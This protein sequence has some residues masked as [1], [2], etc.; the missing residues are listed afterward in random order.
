M[1]VPAA[2][3]LLDVWERGASE[4]PVSRA[5]LLLSVALPATS[6][7][8]LTEM[9]LEERDTWLLSL[10][11]TLF[12]P[13]LAIRTACRHCGESLEAALSV[14]DVRL[15]AGAPAPLGRHEIDGY[16]LSLRAAS[17][18][19]LIAAAR[20]G[21]ASRTR[22]ALFE[23]CV[24][25]ARCSAAGPVSVRALPAHVANAISERLAAAHP[26]ADFR[27]DFTCPACDRAWSADFDVGSFLWQELSAWVQR[28]LRDVA[29]LA[30]AYGWTERESLA[31]SPTRRHLYLELSRA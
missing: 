19:D 5:L 25:E 12:G 9:S 8:E 31:L 20:L 21:D 13:Q 14:D 18:A 7:G 2:E 22:S 4:A 24:V 29:S 6:V 16:E 30:R 10:R 23:R 15:S 17:S 1:R 28:T 26:L 3:E 27:L 11:E